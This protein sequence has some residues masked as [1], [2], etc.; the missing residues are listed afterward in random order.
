MTE[1]RMPGFLL[2]SSDAPETLSPRDQTLLKL[3]RLMA[4]EQPPEPAAAEDGGDLIDPG[5]LTETGPA[6][7]PEP[8]RRPRPARPAARRPP[9][10]AGRS[11]GH[12]G[13]ALEVFIVLL[14]VVWVFLLGVLVGRSRPEESG[15][16]LVG[17]LEKLAGWAPPRPLLLS[18]EPAPPQAPNPGPTDRPAGPAEVPGRSGPE[19]DEPA[20]RTAL[21]GAEPAE[22]EPAGPS[23]PLFAVQAAL[24]HDETEARKQ[25]ARLEAHGFT[26]YF[27]Q[28]AG[29]FPVRVGPFPTRSEAEEHRR[30]LENLGYK[31]S[32]VSQLR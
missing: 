24:A 14:V 21:P 17:W 5:E 4:E 19:L 10:P 26:A 11:A 20:A 1:R 22:E 31:G 25:A 15:H 27:Y 18:P 12:L 8:A 2:R 13:R 28:D 6:A 9:R 32:Y 30:R 16:R 7:R 29:R 3:E 23:G